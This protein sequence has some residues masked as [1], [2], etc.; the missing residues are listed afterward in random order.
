MLNIY[1]NL[2][3]ERAHG[4]HFLPLHVLA[5]ADMFALFLGPF[6]DFV[7]RL[8]DTDGIENT[9]NIVCKVNTP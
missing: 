5:F 9:H 2:C 4:T 3:I 8:A 1:S 7:N 6:Q